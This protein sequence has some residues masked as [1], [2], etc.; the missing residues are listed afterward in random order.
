[1]GSMRIDCAPVRIATWEELEAYMDGSAGSV[2]RIMAPLLGVPAR[3]HAGYGRLGPGLPAHELHPRRARGPA[4]DRIYLPARGPRAL[5]RRRRPTWRAPSASPELRALLALRGPPRA[6]AVRRGRA[7][8]RRGAGLRAPRRP[9]R[10]RASTCACSTAS[11]GS[12]STCSGARDRRAAVAAAGRRAGG[13]APVTRRATL[14][15]AERTPL[16]RTRADV[17]VC[18]ASFAGWRS[19]ASWPAPAPTCSSSTATRSASARRRRAPR[20]RRGW[21]RWACAARSARSCRAWP[22]TRRTARRAS[23][24]RGAGRRSTTARCAR[25]C[26]RSAATRASRSR[27]SSGADRRRP[28]RTDRGDR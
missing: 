3:H 23:G 5:R 13:A 2:G 22:S 18:G 21:R 9:L 8:G 14:R 1:M 20:R 6:R 27:R 16:R 10:R 12:S 19:R 17:L 28:S 7:G 4:L 15:G 25:S 26:G 24:C 11:S